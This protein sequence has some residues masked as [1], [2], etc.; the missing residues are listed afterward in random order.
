MLVHSMKLQ[1]ILYSLHY[2]AVEK[3]PNLLYNDIRANLPREKD[4]VQYA[5]IQ[6]ILY[7]LHCDAVEKPLKLPNS[8]IRAYLTHKKDTVQYALIQSKLYSL[9]CD[10]VEKPLKSSNS[11]FRAYFTLKKDIQSLLNLP[12]FVQSLLFSSHRA[13][14]TLEI[15]A[16]CTLIL[17]LIECSHTQA[18]FPPQ[19]GFMDQL[20][21]FH[22]RKPSAAHG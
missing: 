17:E 9:H 13:D 14:L 10:A 8:D 4:I 21:V 19:S 12:Y 3:P 20:R 7:S 16:S 22:G 2:D 6:S 5:L 15:R 18:L 1:S 11:D